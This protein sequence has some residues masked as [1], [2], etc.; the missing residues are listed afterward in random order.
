MSDDEEI[1]WPTPSYDRPGVCYPCY[2]CG[3]MVIPADGDKEAGLV[4]AASTTKLCGDCAE[5]IEDAIARGEPLPPH[6]GGGAGD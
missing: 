2:R 1:E 3:D 6:A 4:R 5:A